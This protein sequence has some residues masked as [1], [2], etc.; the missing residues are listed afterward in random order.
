MSR[1]SLEEEIRKLKDDLW[2]VE[3]DECYNTKTKNDYDKKLSVINEKISVL[4][5]LRTRE[6]LTRSYVNSIKIALKNAK[7]EV[8][9][10]INV[11]DVAVQ[12][13]SA[14]ALYKEA[15]KSVNDSTP[16]KFSSTIETING[17]SS[18]IN[19]FMQ[20]K[21]SKS[22]KNIDTLNERIVAQ[23][24]DTKK[25]LDKE[26]DEKEKYDKLRDDVVDK[27]YYL[28]RQKKNIT[29]QIEQKEYELKY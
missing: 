16:K 14:E 24:E 11:K 5:T 12:I 6:K 8:T 3:R 15:Y 21:F 17:I 20:N 29:S 19:S 4:N 2:Y 23:M 10:T 7:D 26:K 27:L 9:K 22:E 18:S 25:K 13:Q 1:E 28:E